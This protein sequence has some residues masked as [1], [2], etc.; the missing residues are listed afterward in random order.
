ML[1]S[2]KLWNHVTYQREY[3]FWLDFGSISRDYITVE[4]AI[5]ENSQCFVA[6]SDLPYTVHL[7]FTKGIRVSYRLKATGSGN[8]DRASSEDRGEGTWNNSSFPVG[9]EDTAYNLAK[10]F[11]HAATLC[12]AKK[13]TF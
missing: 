7:N 8:G 11:K 10:A 2:G 5:P 6:K 9:S 4:Q 3:H 12:G 13:E 1:S